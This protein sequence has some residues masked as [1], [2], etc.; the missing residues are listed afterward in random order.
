MKN[1]IITIVVF[2]LFLLP[3]GVNNLYAADLNF[4]KGDVYWLTQN[5]YHEARGE[6][7]YGQLMIG[8]VTLDRLHS[9]KW[10]D[11]I[12][13]VVTAPSQFSWYSDNKS[14]VPTDKKA[15]HGSISVAKLSLMLYSNMKDHKIMYYHNNNVHP[16]WAN[17]MIKI[18]TIGNHTFYR[19]KGE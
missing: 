1:I 17:K 6:N 11:T 3:F 10:G 19:P 5:I 7:L 8:I 12:K 2:I 15:W 9:G 13:E 16:S 18:I 4:T 14:D